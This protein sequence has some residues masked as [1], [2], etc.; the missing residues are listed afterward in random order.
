MKF[1]W[2]RGGL[3]LL[4]LGILGSIPGCGVG[5][6]ATQGWYQG[7]LLLGRIPVEQALKRPEV[8]DL[9]RQRLALIGQV[10]TFGETLGMTPTQNYTTINLEWHETIY[11]VTACR[12]LAFEA[13][14]WW[15]P[16]VGTVPYKGFF[17][18]ADAEAQA[19][20]LQQ[21]GWEVAVREVGGYSTLGWFKDPILPHMLQYDEPE[22]AN[23]ILH[24]L[25]HSTLFIPGKIDFNESFASFVA[26]VSTLR[27]LEATFGPQSTLLIETQ[28]LYQDRVLYQR[29]MHS[30]YTRLDSVYKGTSSEQEKRQLRK[31]V[32]DDIPKAWAELPFQSRRFQQRKAPRPS[33]PDLMQFRRYS[34]EQALFARVLETQGGSLEG[35]FAVFRPVV[36]SGEDPV[37][38]LKRLAG[39]STQPSH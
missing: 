37:L 6:L 7:R 36:R 24:E 19:Q 39:D 1:G 12:E 13:F 21:S 34:G 28:R 10:R 33:N 17:K 30:L 31:D 14:T 18:K 16:I 23:L 20:R 27:F 26:D 22:L 32:L 2:K 8:T 9:Q 15:F 35:F 29:F 38:A 25:T 11:N 5:Y 4:A 3:I